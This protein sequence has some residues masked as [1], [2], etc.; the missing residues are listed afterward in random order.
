[1]SKKS[2]VHIYNEVITFKFLIITSSREMV[3]GTV[4]GGQDQ[5]SPL[6]GSSHLCSEG[7]HAINK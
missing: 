7:V 4:E 2:H 5:R 1:M 3:V 6:G